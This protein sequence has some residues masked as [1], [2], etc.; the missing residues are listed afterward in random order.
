MSWLLI[1]T[2]LSLGAVIGW[3]SY[4]FQALFWPFLVSQIVI[5][6]MLLRIVIL[7]LIA[8][9]AAGNDV[10]M[11]EITGRIFGIIPAEL[12]II[13]CWSLPAACFARLVVYLYAQS[14]PVTVPFETKDM[15]RERLKSE[16]GLSHIEDVTMIRGRSDRRT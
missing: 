3:T 11:M 7:P 4:R 12:V 15:K 16:F 8:A 13:L 1:I 5:G 10:S 9:A 2:G 6:F 14:H